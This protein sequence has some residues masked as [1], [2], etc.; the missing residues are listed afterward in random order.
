M[1]RLKR[2]ARYHDLVCN[3]GRFQRAAALLTGTGTPFLSLLAFADWLYARAGA[4]TGIALPR[5]AALLFEHLTSILGVPAGEAADAI[6]EDYCGGTQRRLP[7][8][9][10]THVTRW[11]PAVP[12]DDSDP[13]FDA[14]PARQ[15]RHARRRPPRPDPA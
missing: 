14:A 8:E 15:R 5:L 12:G 2:T 9:I 6:A 13:R 10:R 1:Q 4:T 11:P 3:S 7:P